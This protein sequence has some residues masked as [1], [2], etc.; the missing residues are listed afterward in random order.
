MV[1]FE[2]K[3][4]NIQILERPASSYPYHVHYNIE[5]VVCTGG[6]LRVTCN[7]E[8]KE[9]HEGDIAIFF[10]NDIHSYKETE[11]GKGIMVIFNPKISELMDKTLH[12]TAYRNF[13]FNSD[14]IPIAQ[15][16]YRQARQE[17]NAITIYGYLHVVVG[18]ILEEDSTNPKPVDPDTLGKAIEFISRNYT[19]KITLSSV[20]AAVGV[21]QS[22]LSR[23]FSAK[24]EGGF[25]RYLQIIRVQKAKNLLASTDLSVYEILEQSGFGDQRTF[26]RVFKTITQFTPLAYR[27]LAQKG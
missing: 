17:A 8:E 1:L 18:M 9:M 19:Q 5:F 15:E 26:N 20:A 27:K 24:I 11:S 12:K 10:S 4:E 16:M 23:L 21:T 13:V 6:V 7:N 2:L 14:V 3:S 22:H 25:K